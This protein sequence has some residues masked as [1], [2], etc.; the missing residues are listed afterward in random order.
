MTNQ[1][2]ETNK[3]NYRAAVCGIYVTA[4]GEFLVT[5]AIKNYKRWGSGHGIDG[6]M[7][8][9]GLAHNANLAKKSTP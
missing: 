9:I 7:L 8:A 3:A 6:D 4:V 1:P 5:E 2:K